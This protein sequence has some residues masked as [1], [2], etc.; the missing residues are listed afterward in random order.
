MVERRHRAHRLEGCPRPAA[1]PIL[2]MLAPV[3]D[4][5][6]ARVAVPVF[7]ELGY[8]HADHRPEE[9]LWFYK[10]PAGDYESRTHQLHLTRSDSRL[11]RER[12]G[13]RVAL[14]EDVGLRDAVRRLEARVRSNPISSHTRTG[15]GRSCQQCFL[16]EVST[17]LPLAK[18][19]SRL[20]TGR[21]NS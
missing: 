6:V 7:A 14:H 18:I 17:S 16:A 3:A 20:A 11:W 21:T 8:R 9:A 5:N 15:T 10:K 1:K 4:L 2:D 12:L 13:F 19:M